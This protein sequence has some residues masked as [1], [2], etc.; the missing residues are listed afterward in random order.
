[1]AEKLAAGLEAIVE[2]H[3]VRACLNR[4]GSMWTLFFGVDAVTDA[5]TAQRTDTKAFARYFQSMLEQGI[6]LP[7]SA[8][9]AAFVSLAHGDG[10]IEDTLASADR[11]IGALASAG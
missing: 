1:M 8:F 7:P 11:A 2:R 10:D 3:G 4:V 6:Y 9:E 5:T